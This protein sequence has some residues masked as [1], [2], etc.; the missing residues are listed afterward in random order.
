MIRGRVPRNLN[1][2]RRSED[3]LRHEMAAA[4]LSKSCLKMHTRIATIS[5]CH[6]TH[7]L[8]GTRLDRSYRSKS[9][10]GIDLY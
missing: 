8:C 9:V 6:I 7:Q 3:G 4:V 10:S 1:I 5:G 2:A